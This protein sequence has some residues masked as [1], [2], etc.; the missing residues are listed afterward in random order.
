MRMIEYMMT[1]KQALIELISDIE[2]FIR[3]HLR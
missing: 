2:S 1:V 3:S